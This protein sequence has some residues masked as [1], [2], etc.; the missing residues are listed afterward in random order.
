MQRWSLHSFLHKP[1]QPSMKGACVPA[2]LVSEKIIKGSE[3][4]FDRQRSQAG[5]PER[6]LRHHEVA[7]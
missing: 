5:A 2:H 4:G 6:P 3:V 7:E 1:E